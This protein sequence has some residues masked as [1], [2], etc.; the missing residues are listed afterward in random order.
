LVASGVQAQRAVKVAEALVY[1][2]LLAQ[3]STLAYVDTFVVLSV[4]AAIMFV[5]SFA[6]RR[7]D[8]AG[9]PVV[10]E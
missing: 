2:T 9:R 8:P 5:L 4:A 1:Q 6:L 10:M 7:N 3:A